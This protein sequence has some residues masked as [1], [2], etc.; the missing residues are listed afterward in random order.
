MRLGNHNQ[1]LRT[2]AAS[3]AVNAS[4]C[5]RDSRPPVAGVAKRGG[6]RRA[7]ARLALCRDA[8]HRLFARPL[9]Q[10][11]CTPRTAIPHARGCEPLA[12]TQRTRSLD[13]SGRLCSR[14]PAS[15]FALVQ[16]QRAQGAMR[17]RTRDPVPRI[18]AMRLEARWLGDEE[19]LRKRNEGL[20]TSLLSVHAPRKCNCSSR[21][22]R[23]CRSS[24]SPADGRRL[25]SVSSKRITRHC[26]APPAPQP[27]ATPCTPF[28]AQ[29]SPP[30][31][32]PC[33]SSTPGGS[34]RRT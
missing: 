13:G 29:A 21:R 24:R 9:Q 6:V 34:C 31:G 17:A 30:S 20:T 10:S 19:A 27:C 32:A 8:Q 4:R 33:S 15:P 14:Q 5:D 23:L 26:S 22:S 28:C 7:A 12:H 18:G 1:G 3:V 25:S 16:N 11:A 2:C